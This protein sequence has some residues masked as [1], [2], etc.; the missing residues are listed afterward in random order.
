MPTSTFAQLVTASS[1]ET[2]S[3]GALSGDGTTGD[4]LAVEVDGST[5]IVNAGNALE[6]GFKS[7]DGTAGATAGPFT[8][9]TAIRV[10]NGYVTTLT[11]S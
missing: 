8:V 5:I 6:N 4:K 1:V 11:G 10:K 7:S 2:A 3:A 9:I